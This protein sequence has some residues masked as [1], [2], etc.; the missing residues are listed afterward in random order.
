MLH[1]IQL[2]VLS[3]FQFVVRA[4]VDY[5]VHLAD[6]DKLVEWN[7]IEQIVSIK[8]KFYLL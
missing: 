8:F 5:S 1:K 7:F 2:K 4:E 6:P 3:S